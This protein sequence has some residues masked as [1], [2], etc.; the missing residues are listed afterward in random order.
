M[1]RPRHLAKDPVR[2]LV[3]VDHRP[4]AVRARLPD[5]HRYRPGPRAV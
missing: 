2:A 4:A 5:R 1:N 3:A